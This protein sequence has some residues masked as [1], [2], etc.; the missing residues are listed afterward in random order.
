MPIILA[1]D[2]ETTGK[3]PKLPGEKFAEN[4]FK[5]AKVRAEAWPRIVQLS[6]I[7]YDTER[8][9]TLQMYDSIIRLRPEQ[10]PIPPESSN[11][12]GISDEK[13][14]NEG[15]P[16]LTALLDFV[17][18]YQ[19]ADFVVGHNIQYDINV[20][21]AEIAL[22]N[23]RKD[24]EENKMLTKTAKSLLQE[25]KTKMSYDPKSEFKFCT[26]HKG[27]ARCNLPR[28]IYGEEGPVIGEDGNPLI[29]YTLDKYGKRYVRGPKLEDAHKLLFHQKANGTLH[30]SLVDVAVSLRIYMELSNNIDIC[31]PEN[32]TI[33]NEA[34][35]ALI[36]PSHIEK[37]EMPKTIADE[38]MID[39][40]K[41]EP[42]NQDEP[43]EKDVLVLASPRR[44][45]RLS[46]KVSPVER[47]TIGDEA[48]LLSQAATL[49][50]E[51]DDSLA[52]GV[53]T[54]AKKA[55]T[56]PHTKKA[57]KSKS[58]NTHGSRRK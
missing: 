44:S 54:R 53:K 38:E 42:P 6:F 13:S 34:I 15:I 31:K 24:E 40:L 35:C 47:L 14:Q 9:T 56:R 10:Y 51:N 4:F 1:Y 55:T 46:T 11:I 5:D 32:R 26:M 2:T 20:I 45:P 48:T 8:M 25:F 12:H 49:F 37:A 16:I 57:H 7:L 33:S 19:H 28:L 27:K 52:R 23:R 58:K 39:V 50:E 30:N 21:L 3:P 29:D 22:V 41:I 18:A 43:I 36:A 17:A